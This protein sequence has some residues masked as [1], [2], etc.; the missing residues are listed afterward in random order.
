MQTVQGNRIESLR[1][2][3]DFVTEHDDRF[4]EVA[5]SGTFRNLTDLVAQVTV[6]AEKQAASRGAGQG[7]TQ[8]VH[9]ARDTLL[10]DHLT[11]I[12]RMSR[13]LRAD[14]PDLAAVRMPDERLGAAKLAS[15]ALEAVPI[16][17]AHADRFIALGLAPDFASRLREAIERMTGAICERAMCRG[18]RAGATAGL[19]KLLR[20][21]RHYV[22]VLDALI[23]TSSRDDAEL[24]AGWDAVSHVRRASVRQRVVAPEE[25]PSRLPLLLPA[26]TPSF[27]P[28]P[29]AVMRINPS[30]ATDATSSPERE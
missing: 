3:L 13:I 14:V 29:P 30:C 12:V 19:R 27:Y 5:R 17:E 15:A 7:E 9:A 18:R 28:F 8:L 21:G 24:V 22:L 20:L 11:P 2:V 16:A 25:V 6:F 26:R 10:L 4:P 1:A 23:R